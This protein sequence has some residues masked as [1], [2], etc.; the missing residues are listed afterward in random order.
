[1]NRS[2]NVKKFLMILS[3]LG[4]CSNAFAESTYEAVIKGKS[5]KEDDRQ[6]IVCKYNI[7]RSLEIWVTGVGIPDVGITFARSDFYNGDYYATYGMMHQCIIIKSRNSIFDM[8]FIS[9]KNGK[10]YED[11]P[12][13]KDSM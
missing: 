8:A 2:Q 4:L 3:F 11:W 1:M 10:V 9:P 5:C 13:C 6:Q 12:T 7:G